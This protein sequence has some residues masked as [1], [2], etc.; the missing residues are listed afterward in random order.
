[1]LAFWGKARN[2]K[3][4]VILKISKPHIF[5]FVCLFVLCRIEFIQG[6]LM[7]VEKVAETGKGRERL[8]G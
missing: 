5:L 4:L 6:K 8:E 2:D 3:H 1:M 7:G